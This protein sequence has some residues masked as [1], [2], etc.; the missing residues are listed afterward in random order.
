MNV[1]KAQEHLAERLNRLEESLRRIE[2]I[3]ET[4]QLSS[5]LE[6]LEKKTSI[7]ADRTADIHQFV[8]FVGWLNS[9]AN[10]LPARLLPPS[11]LPAPALEDG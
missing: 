10:L 7:V 11:A 8:P 1:E 2:T 5:R 6:E 9:V 4:A 3:L